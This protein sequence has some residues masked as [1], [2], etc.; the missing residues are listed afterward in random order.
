M[1]ISRFYGDINLLFFLLPFSIDSF[2]A[3]EGTVK[4]YVQ[5]VLKVQNEADPNNIGGEQ[6]SLHFIFS[7][8]SHV[9]IRFK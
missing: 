6:S 7:D 8:A 4:A 1:E 2:S 3:I 9:N 5:W